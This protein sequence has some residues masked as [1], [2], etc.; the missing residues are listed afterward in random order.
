[1]LYTISTANTKAFQ[2]MYI[3]RID[4]PKI[5]SASRPL[6]RLLLPPDHDC[7]KVRPGMPVRIEKPRV[8]IDP[9]LCLVETDTPDPLTLMPVFLFIGIRLKKVKGMAFIW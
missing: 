7:L 3:K 2:A 8:P 4:S 9:Y 1:M 6:V 5:K